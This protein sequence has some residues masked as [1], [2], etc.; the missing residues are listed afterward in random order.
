MDK[1]IVIN[2][3]TEH[4][5]SASITNVGDLFPDDLKCHCGKWTWGELNEQ[6][7]EKEIRQK[8]L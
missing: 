5:F 8:S 3:R 1:C 6:D 7:K 2:G 4:G